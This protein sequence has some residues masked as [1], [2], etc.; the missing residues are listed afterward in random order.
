MIRPQRSH[1]TPGPGSRRGFTLI[2]LLV[3]ILIIG[4]LLSITLI[5]GNYALRFARKA[6]TERFLTSIATGIEQFKADHNYYPP[7]LGKIPT[8]TP[9]DAPL[10]LESQPNAF[11][12]VSAPTGPGAVTLARSFSILS[13]TAYLVGVGDINGDGKTAYRNPSYPAD[14]PRNANLDDGVDGPGLRSPGPDRSWGGATRRPQT[15]PAT[16]SDP[17]IPPQTGRV[18]GPYINVANSK[19][20]RRLKASDY[21][22]ETADRTP[23]GLGTPT[24][25]ELYTLVDRWDSPIRYYRGWAVKQDPAVPTSAS[26]LENAPIELLS[27]ESVDAFAGSATGPGMATAGATDSKLLAAPYVLLSAG[28]DGLFGESDVEPSQTQSTRMLAK[29]LAG[30]SASAGDRLKKIKT[31]IA[32]N[33][34]YV[35]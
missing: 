25:I 35:P 19:S 21:A 4:V 30:M 27:P 32:D 17:P 2:E 23:I 29:D 1:A 33:V 18:Y 31:R 14:D 24:A 13:L 22:T 9:P 3:V 16:E 28:E 26:S 34:R 7:L 6:S 8:A 11:N 20:V 10:V 5:A 12:T 15:L